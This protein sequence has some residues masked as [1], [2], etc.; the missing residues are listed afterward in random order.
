MDKSRVTKQRRLMDE[1]DDENLP[2]RDEPYPRRGERDT[3]GKR[4]EPD[5]RRGD[6]HLP[7][8]ARGQSGYARDRDGDLRKERPKERSL[9]PYSRRLA[10]T[11]AMNISR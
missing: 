3:R 8:N 6:G 9:S 7:G 10:L 5:R 2:P 4:N 11:Q 1:D